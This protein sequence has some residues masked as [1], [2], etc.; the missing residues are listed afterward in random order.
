[1]TFNL[2]AFGCSFTKYIWPT[3]ADILGHYAKDYINFGKA[4]SGSYYS[5]NQLIHFVTNRN[6]T[7]QDIVAICWSTPYREDRIKNSKWLF[8]GP[9]SHPNAKEYQGNFIEELFDVGHYLEL[10]RTFVL[11]AIEILE[12]K[13]VNYIMFSL[14]N[15]LLNFNNKKNIVENILNNL[16]SDSNLFYKNL[17]LQIEKNEQYSDYSKKLLTPMMDYLNL[18]KNHIRPTLETEDGILVPDYHPT[19]AEHLRYL[20]NV[21]LPVLPFDININN[22]HRLLIEKESEQIFQQVNKALKK[23]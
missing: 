22:E 4:R 21:I 8:S 13:N 19:P 10:Q 5:F 12:A 2:Y 3:W 1:M 20:E 11:S 18:R 7:E 16:G 23:V 9:L 6:L 14:D 15:I 17:Q